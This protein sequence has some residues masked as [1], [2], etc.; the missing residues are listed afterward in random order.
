[1]RV[2]DKKDC[3][4]LATYG[5]AINIV[6]PDLDQPCRIMPNIVLCGTHRKSI[7]FNNVFNKD[8][9]D[10][11]RAILEHNKIYEMP[12]LEKSKLDFIPM[13]SMN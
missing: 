10:C 6:I 4:K 11:L 5:V 13:F 12:S 1:M 9:K 7:R 8:M 3:M 2:C